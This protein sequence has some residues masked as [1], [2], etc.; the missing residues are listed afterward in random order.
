MSQPVADVFAYCPRCGHDRGDQRGNPLRCPACDYTHF[1]SP[2]SAVG[3]FIVDRDGRYLFITR[4]RDPQAGKLGIPGGFVDPGETVEHALARE[5]REEVG[6][7]VTAFEFV[8]S[9]P[10]TYDFKGVILPVADLFFT[11]EVASHDV[12]AEASEVADWSF[13]KPTADTLAAMAFESNRIA[14]QEVVRRRAT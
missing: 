1:F 8:M 10:N 5:V 11:C 12:A 9:S 2:T 6:L 7:E 14:L 3:A 4:Q 13:R